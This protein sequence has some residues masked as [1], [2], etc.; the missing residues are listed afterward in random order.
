MT[1]RLLRHRE[2]GVLVRLAEMAQASAAA[3]AALTQPDAPDLRQHAADARLARRRLAEE[4]AD[5]LILPF[6]PEEV[7]E[8][9]ERLEAVTAAAYRLQR[10]QR[11][12]E[13]RGG[14]DL[15][16]LLATA[17]ETAASTAQAIALLARDP[18]AAQQRAEDVLDH[19]WDAEDAYG[20][21]LQRRGRSDVPGSEGPALRE[22]ARRAQ[23]LHER[24]AHAA[25]RVVHAV[26]K[27]S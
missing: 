13:V 12:L 23:D 25:R 27:R 16:A 7:L 6:D 8:L 9:S 11:L 2:P 19:Q 3:V 22:L 15:A 14:A 21:L 10:E 20:A 17:A 4:V 24:I 26:A 1:P 5:A 18:R